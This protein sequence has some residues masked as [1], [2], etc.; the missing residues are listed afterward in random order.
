MKLVSKKNYL[1]PWVSRLCYLFTAIKKMSK[2]DFPN[3]LI[4]KT[5][6]LC[7]VGGDAILYK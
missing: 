7:S 1:N 3:N 4:L 6:N 2:T 5:S